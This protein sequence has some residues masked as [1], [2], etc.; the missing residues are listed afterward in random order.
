MRDYGFDEEVIEEMVYETNNLNEIT[1]DED[2]Q[3]IY[4][5]NDDRKIFSLYGDDIEELLIK[6]QKKRLFLYFTRR[7]HLSEKSAVHFIS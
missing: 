2:I 5:E 6:F 3:E 4:V 7:E 1:F